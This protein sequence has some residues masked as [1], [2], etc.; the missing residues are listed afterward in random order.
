NAMLTRKNGLTTQP[1]LIYFPNTLTQLDEQ[2]GWLFAQDGSAYLAVRPASGTY[3]WLTT[4]KNQATDINNRFIQLSDVSSPMIF[5]AAQA[6]QYSSFNA[7]KLKIASNSRSY[8]NGVLNYTASNGTKLTLYD[9]STTPMINGTPINFLP[10][11]MMS[12]PFIH[13]VYGSG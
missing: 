11:N 5:E 10:T 12:S 13:S 8:V 7:F 2:A 6:G 9:N 1:T 4:A 3:H